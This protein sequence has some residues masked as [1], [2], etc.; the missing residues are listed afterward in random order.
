MAINLDILSTEDL[1]KLSE[2]DF[3]GISD[4]GL[5][6]L[7]GVERTAGEVASRG[8]ERGVT[9]LVGG[10]A[11][12]GKE[13]DGGARN[14]FE[15]EFQTGAESQERL[16]TED[17]QTVV[18]REAEEEKV[19]KYEARVGRE[20]SPWIAYSTEIVGNIVGDPTNLVAFGPKGIVKGAL[21]LAGVGGATGGLE[22]VD[23]EVGE[24]RLTNLA[25]GT[26]LGGVIGGVAG[27]LAKRS[28]DLRKAIDPSASTKADDVAPKTREEIEAE[29]PTLTPNDS[30]PS[31]LA[32]APEG[33]QK[34]VDDVLSRYDDD[35]VVPYSTFKEMSEKVE[36]SRLAA[37]FKGAS[38]PPPQAAKVADETSEAAKVVPSEQPVRDVGNFP[39]EATEDFRKAE[40]TGDYREL[41]KTSAVR[42]ADLSRSAFEKIFNKRNPYAKENLKS[43]LTKN[44]EGEETLKDFLD[45][46]RARNVYERGGTKGKQTTEELEQDA[47]SIPG[48][49]AIDALANRKIEEQVALPVIYRAANELGKRLNDLDKL[50]EL[51]LAAKELGSDEAYAV[52]QKEIAEI[53]GLINSLEGS[54]SNTARTLAF[55]RKIKEQFLSR[56]AG[57]PEFAAKNKQEV[58][59]FFQALESIPVGRTP[60][61]TIEIKTKAVGKILKQPKWTDKVAEYVINSYISALG[62]PAVNLL[63]TIGKAVTLIPER[64]IQSVVS[65]AS[66]KF[67]KNERVYLREAVEMSR[68]IVEGLSEAM[69][70]IKAGFLKGYSLDNDPT[71][72]YITKAIGGQKD[73]VKVERYFGEAVRVP[74]RVGVAVDELSKAVFRRMQLNALAYR[75]SRNIPEEKLNGL[76]RDE[77]YNNLRRV[78]IGQVDPASLKPRWKE[79]LRKADID[80]SSDIIND[81]E[82]FAITNTFQRKLGKAGNAVLEFRKE[83]PLFTLVMPFIK[84]PINIVTDALTYT[85]AALWMKSAGGTIEQRLARATMGSGLAY[86]TYLQVMSGNITGSYPTNPAERNA[87]IASSIPEY[88]VRIGDRWYSYARI[89]PLA[90]VLGVSADFSNKLPTYFGKGSKGLQELDKA[91]IDVALTFTKNITSK[92]FL[93]SVTGLLQAVH[94][95]QRYGASFLSSYANTIVPGAVSQV[96]RITDPVQRQVDGFF[97][98]IYNR[99]P[100][101]RQQLPVK[102]D[103]LGQERA[104]RGATVPGLLGVATQPARQTV[105]QD[106]I[107]KTKFSFSPPSKKLGGIELSNQD[108]S[109]L[110]RLS[111]DRVNSRLTNLVNNPNFQSLPVARQKYIMENFAKQERKKAAEIML[112]QKLRDP[113][114]RKEYQNKK[115]ESKGLE[116]EE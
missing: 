38:E 51:Y 92:T 18:D 16:A 8:L 22:R 81:I 64:V 112:R 69:D 74:T 76:S 17:R 86:M 83:H 7:A 10:L 24:S 1:K 14:T 108:Y 68:G 62:T 19:R 100:G 32:R 84:T 98:G 94:D 44:V 35:E 101:L 105:L 2:G 63:S 60:E 59:D 36:N 31:L 46:L 26:A 93:E 25:L 27:G 42:T 109:M 37:L 6:Y 57:L 72:D 73:A 50:K 53:G 9:S 111:G 20:E 75:T 15:A 45:N 61:E 21:Y 95:P 99:V 47:L 40:T 107:E 33:D 4:T 56:G 78:D 13:T 102:Y 39:F 29:L 116:L 85:P 65:S 66:S 104:E 48:K 30:L 58:D 12:L 55:T 103:I 34:Y 23:E 5:R 90:S 54:I 96:A 70:L 87:L 28:D 89:E 41:L 11:Q 52:L 80:I 79:E 113:E 97:D 106:T 82:D 114:F 49:V 71:S 67:T 110:S 77:L 3:D 115:R 43:F 88:S 91:L